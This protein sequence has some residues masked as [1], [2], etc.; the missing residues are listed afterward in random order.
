VLPNKI[1]AIDPQLLI[2]QEY[3]VEGLGAVVE[4]ASL[5]FKDDASADRGQF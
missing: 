3:N 4:S 5:K 1:G 2:Q